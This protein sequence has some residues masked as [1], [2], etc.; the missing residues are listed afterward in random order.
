MA[1][2]MMVV[3]G[4]GARPKRGP[5]LP[6]AFR[7]GE[8]QEEAKPEEEKPEKAPCAHMQ[9]CPFYRQEEEEGEEEEE[10]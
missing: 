8:P 7:S 10:K 3:I 1:K 2:G 4:V 9:I 5:G 6:G